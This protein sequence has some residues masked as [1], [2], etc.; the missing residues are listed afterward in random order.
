MDE[1]INFDSIIESELIILITNKSNE[2]DLGKIVEFKTSLMPILRYSLDPD[3]FPV[4]FHR[5]QF[6]I[7]SFK[8]L[9]TARIL[10]SRS[11]LSRLLG[12]LL[13][14]YTIEFFE[15]LNSCESSPQS[16]SF[17][18]VSLSSLYSEFVERVVLCGNANIVFEVLVQKL[19]SR[20]RHSPR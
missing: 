19:L 1:I 10:F 11:H 9:E 17:K 18:V 6:N 4:F 13:L 5:S 7:N 15:K 3:Q 2:H 8:E 20:Q 16:D 14:S 12:S